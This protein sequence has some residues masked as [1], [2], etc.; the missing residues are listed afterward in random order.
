MSQTLQA[1]GSSP[2]GKGPNTAEVSWRD[3]SVR[4]GHTERVALT[5]SITRQCKV[6]GDADIDERGLVFITI[7]ECDGKGNLP[8]LNRDTT[9]YYGA[10]E[11]QGLSLPGVGHWIN[12]ATGLGDTVDAAFERTSVPYDIVVFSRQKTRPT[13][14]RS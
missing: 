10:P 4:E 8:G 2:R 3:Y 14:A 5:E 9:R 11:D 13:P 1:A 6:V 7:Q 12:E